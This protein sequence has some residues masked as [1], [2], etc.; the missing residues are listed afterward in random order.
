MTTRR[1][2]VIG[3]TSVIA[4]HVLRAWLAAGPA[5]VHLIGR[6]AQRLQD[7]QRDLTVRHPESHFTFEAVDLVDVDEIDR[8][9]ARMVARTVDAG[10]P[11][12]V[13]IAHGSLGSQE[14]AQQDLRAAHEQLVVTGVSPALWLEAFADRMTHGTLAI[15]GS[16]AGDRGRRS[17]YLYGAG[18]SLIEHVAQGLQH[19][20][21]STELHIVLIKPG[22]T[23]TP[24]T[25]QL[26]QFGARLADVQDVAERI[27]AAVIARRPV[28]YAPAVWRPIMAAVRSIPRPIFNRLDL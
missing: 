1:I 15:V 6:H 19:R 12:I 9:V 20:F 17:N 27:A 24:M 4:Q 16:V 8:T 10:E 25:D 18:K 22:P 28:V 11:D 21:A 2:V 14:T 26:A 13:L 23:R 7:V 5:S 3:G